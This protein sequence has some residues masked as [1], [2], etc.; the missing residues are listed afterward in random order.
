MEVCNLTYHQKKRL[1][2]MLIMIFLL[3]PQFLSAQKEDNS[4][5]RLEF[6]SGRDWYEYQYMPI[7]QHGVVLM[8]KGKLIHQDTVMWRF[9]LYD[10]NFSKVT[11]KEIKL[12]S[13]LN[14]AA[15]HFSGDHLYF[16]FQTASNRK[17]PN[18]CF[19]VRSKVDQIALSGYSPELFELHIDLPGVNQITAV[20]NHLFLFSSNKNSNSFC[21]Y[22]LEKQVETKKI[23]LGE[24]VTEFL[25]LD[26]TQQKLL[27]AVN[28]YGD[29]RNGVPSGFV[30]Y[31]SNYDGSSVR[32]ITFPQYD[33]YQ[34]RSARIAKT[35]SDNYLIVGT[36]SNQTDKRSSNLHTGVY[37]L[38][39]EKGSMGYPNFF[40]YTSLKTRDAKALAKAQNNN[41][42]LQL[43][44]GDLYT[45]GQ[46]YGFVTEVYYPE[47]STSNYYAPGSYYVSTPVST[48]EG[49]RFLNAY[50][51]TFDK[52]GNLLWDHFMP[53]N[54]MLTQS[55]HAKVGLFIDT[56]NNG[57][58]YYPHGN[59]IT[60]TLINHYTVLEP[61]MA[62]K[63]V[64]LHSRDNI[65]STSQV[66]LERWFGNNFILTG[67]Q[68]IRNPN[69]GKSGRRF[70]FFLNRLQYR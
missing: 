33:E 31:E 64:S 42:N 53:I 21:F 60:S 39:F 54:E 18:R 15:T 47:Y 6:E 1:A 67:Y 7:A 59:S 2:G 44:I 50:I 46:Q 70:V 16:L 65:E 61:I 56:E 13:N 62:E 22:E 40:N 45:N 8:N 57:Y 52:K 49:Y 36:Y 26:T 5:L 20:N 27:V 41:L 43:V 25:L 10:T 24:S 32:A 17:I 4:P 69:F 29:P 23:E 30:V 37:T 12:I 63:M 19:L 28:Q 11:Q 66:K 48:F 58:I 9:T 14:L 34:Y 38:A 51:T 55:L 3:I 35:G 68:S